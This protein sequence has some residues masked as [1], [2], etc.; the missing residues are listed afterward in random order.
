VFDQI[1]LGQ[2]AAYNYGY[3][4]NNTGITLP[5]SSYD[6]ASHFEPIGSITGE[7]GEAALNATDDFMSFG[8]EQ[9]GQIMMQWFV[10]KVLLGRPAADVAPWQKFVSW[11]QTH[12]QV[13]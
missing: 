12:P 1:V 4:A 8:P 13:A 11:V 2:E 5:N 7:N 6:G 10:R 3:D 9:Q